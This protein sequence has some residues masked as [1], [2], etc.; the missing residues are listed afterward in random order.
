MLPK[1]SNHE[2]GLDGPTNWM[3][4]LVYDDGLLEK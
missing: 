1:T 3:Y 2:K 4:F